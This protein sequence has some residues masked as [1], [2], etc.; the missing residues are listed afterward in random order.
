MGKASQNLAKSLQASKDRYDALRKA[1]QADAPRVIA[2]LRKQ[3]SLRQIARRIGRSPTYVSM[4]ANSLVVC[5][6]DVY[7]ALVELTGVEE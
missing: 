4:V 1:S 7:V 6:D 5:S 2:E 3:M